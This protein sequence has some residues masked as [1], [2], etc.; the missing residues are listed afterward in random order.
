MR[1]LPQYTID[2]LMAILQWTVSEL[3]YYACKDAVE[4]ARVGRKL[5]LTQWKPAVLNQCSG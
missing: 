2:E 4:E 1:P 5:R 3:A